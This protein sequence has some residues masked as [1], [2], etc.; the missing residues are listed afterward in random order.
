MPVNYLEGTIPQVHFDP[1]L[2]VSPYTLFRRFREGNPPPLLDV[3]SEGG[4]LSLLG[5]VRLP[6]EDWLPHP[7]DE[8]VVFD[9]EGPLALDHAR[10]MHAAG[11]PR[12]RALFGG[13]A[14]Y[15]FALDPEV[16]GPET[17]LVRL[18]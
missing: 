4:P 10:R 18:P 3:R 15:D 2:E 11:R 13:L 9:D 16:V 6:A 17:F 12:V 1:L 8:V 14:L 5:A 7:E